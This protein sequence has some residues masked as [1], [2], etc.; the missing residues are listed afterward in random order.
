LSRVKAV[1]RTQKVIN[2]RKKAGHKGA[3]A[4]DSKSKKAVKYS[5]VGSQRTRRTI[6][7]Q[8]AAA[9]RKAAKGK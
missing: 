9:A 6:Q 8:V 7:S 1:R 4:P 3:I 2:A 5:T